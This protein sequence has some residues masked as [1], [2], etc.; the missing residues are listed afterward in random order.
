MT[1]GETH[2]G[3]YRLVYRAFNS[4][5]EPVNCGSNPELSLYSNTHICRFM[6]RGCRGN[7]CFQATTLQKGGGGVRGQTRRLY[8]PL[9]TGSR[10]EPSLKSKLLLNVSIKWT[11]V[12]FNFSFGHNDHEKSRCCMIIHKFCICHKSFM[13]NPSEGNRVSFSSEN[14]EET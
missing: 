5:N 13:S 12:D 2:G 10:K 7:R 9:V 1:V 3:L 4:H 11:S 14:T 6:S 8:C